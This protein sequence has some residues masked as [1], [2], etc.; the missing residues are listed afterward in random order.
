MSSPGRHVEDCSA[1]AHPAQGKGGMYRCGANP[2]PTAELGF[3]PYIRLSPGPGQSHFETS[4]AISDV[5]PCDRRSVSWTPALRAR[6]RVTSTIRVVG[7]SSHDHRVVAMVAAGHAVGRRRLGAADVMIHVNQDVAAFRQLDDRASEKPAGCARD[8]YTDESAWGVP[9]FTGAP[10][11][12]P[13][14][15]S[16]C[17]SGGRGRQFADYSSRESFGGLRVRSVEEPSRH[18]GKV[19]R[20]AQ[21]FEHR[22]AEGRRP[23]ERLDERRRSAAI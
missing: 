17:F 10:R 11:S 7:D 13:R 5:N 21:P 18:H 14:I 20:H 8:V 1:M 2:R 9:Q 16:A 22:Y 4:C 3:G 12:Y 19:P 15:A 6:R 23:G